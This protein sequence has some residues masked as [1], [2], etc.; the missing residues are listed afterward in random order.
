MKANEPILATKLADR[1]VGGGLPVI[2]PQGMRAM[3]I[4]VDEIVGVAGFVTPGTRVDVLLTVSLPGQREPDTRVIMQ[5]VQAL[6]AGQ[7]IQR[8]EEG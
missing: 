7:T 5:N 3:S 8:D 4:K 6:A 2:I 1:G